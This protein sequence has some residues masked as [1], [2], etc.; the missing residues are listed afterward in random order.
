[1]SYPVPLPSL[2]VPSA[3]AAITYS[4]ITA[5]SSAA[6]IVMHGSFGPRRV[7]TWDRIA[8]S[9]ASAAARLMTFRPSLVS[10]R[11][12]NKKVMTAIGV[13]GFSGING[14]RAGI[15]FPLVAASYNEELL[16]HDHTPDTPPDSNEMIFLDPPYVW[17]K[18]SHNTIYTLSTERWL[19]AGALA[20]PVTITA[21]LSIIICTIL[22]LR[23]GRYA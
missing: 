2:P 19:L 21:I 6:V 4:K 14:I 9:F 1:M 5:A 23:F 12:N 10:A 15:V 3:A 22:C 8:S 20:D 16:K 13:L 17:P 11:A 18:F 7:W